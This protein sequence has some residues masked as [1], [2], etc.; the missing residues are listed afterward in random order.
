MGSGALQAV[1][2]IYA[3]VPRRMHIFLYP[4]YFSA[5]LKCKTLSQVKVV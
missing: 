1:L 4:K 5:F 3:A 2:K